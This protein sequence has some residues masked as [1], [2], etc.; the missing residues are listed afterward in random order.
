MV[1]IVLRMRS[2]VVGGRSFALSAGADAMSIIAAID[3][4]AEVNGCIPAASPCHTLVMRNLDRGADPRP[5][6]VTAPRSRPAPDRCRSSFEPAF[7]TCETARY[8][9]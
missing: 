4:R 3:D 1:R 8:W 9:F 7:A 6:D 2:G 5:S